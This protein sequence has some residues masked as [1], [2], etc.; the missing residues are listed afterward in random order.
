M[1]DKEESI[2]NDPIVI[3]NLSDADL[4]E[5]VHKAND[6][7]Y[8]NH[9]VQIEHK[10]RRSLKITQRIEDAKKRQGN[11]DRKLYSNIYIF[12]LDN[13]LRNEIDDTLIDHAMTYFNKL[14]FFKLRAE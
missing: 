2:V 3:E 12:D 11:I 13:T 5:E 10:K 8:T 14:G 1:I 9:P 6:Q 4:Q 7:N